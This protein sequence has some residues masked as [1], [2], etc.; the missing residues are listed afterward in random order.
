MTKKIKKLNESIIQKGKP[1][2][3]IQDYVKVHPD[4]FVKRK[5]RFD[6]SGIPTGKGVTFH[7]HAKSFFLIKEDFFSDKYPFDFNPFPANGVYLMTDENG[8]ILYSIHGGP[9]EGNLSED[10]KNET[11][12]DESDL[13]F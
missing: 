1:D 9:D 2:T 10:N 5:P 3:Y 11:S 4:A 12:I 13:P 8:K 7:S 6:F